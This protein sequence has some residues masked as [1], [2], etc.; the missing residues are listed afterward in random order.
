MGWGEGQ[1]TYTLNLER[2]FVLCMFKEPRVY[3]CPNNFVHECLILSWKR[4]F[5]FPVVCYSVFRKQTEKRHTHANAE[6]EF[7]AFC[8]LLT[9]FFS[10]RWKTMVGNA[11]SVELQ[12][13]YFILAKKKGRGT[14]QWGPFTTLRRTC[15]RY[16]TFTGYWH[17][18]MYFPPPK[19]WPWGRTSLKNYVTLFWLVI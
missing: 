18:G 13:Y 16:C 7:W 4:K 19:D 10:E 2:I 5:Y 6:P 9:F 12:F 11:W 14:W 17:Q 1:A 8:G 3:N 15:T